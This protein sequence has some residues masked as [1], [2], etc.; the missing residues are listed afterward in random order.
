MTERRIWAASAALFWLC[1]G[2]LLTLGGRWF[3]AAGLLSGVAGMLAS[4]RSA[5]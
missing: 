5:E 4:R 3:W 1:A 2:V